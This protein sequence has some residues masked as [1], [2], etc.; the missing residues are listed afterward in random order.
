MSFTPVSAASKSQYFLSFLYSADS[1]TFGY[2]SAANTGRE[3]KEDI[4]SNLNTNKAM[5][6]LTVNEWGVVKAE[7]DMIA[8]TEYLSYHPYSFPEFNDV[9]GS[10]QDYSMSLSVGG[11]L[12]KSLNNAMAFVLKPVS[13]A[14]RK[15]MKMEQPTTVF[16]L[17]VALSNAGYDII[18]SNRTTFKSFEYGKL[19]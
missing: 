6:K 12:T 10:S 8:D 18:S 19:K 11:S 9:D 5:F 4:Y 16:A 15:E 7:N 14:G 13:T 17:A 1:R 3:S 2:I